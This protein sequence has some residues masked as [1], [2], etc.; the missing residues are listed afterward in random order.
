[1]HHELL[2]LYLSISGA[3]LY[4]SRLLMF[5]TEYPLT[6]HSKLI[7]RHLIKYELD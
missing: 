3:Q 7:L 1:M 5:A 6:K 2:K 4:E